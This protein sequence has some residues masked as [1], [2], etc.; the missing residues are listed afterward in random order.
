ME[1]PAIERSYSLIFLFP[2]AMGSDLPE[3]QIQTK[4]VSTESKI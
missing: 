3:S 1:M 2:I 4:A